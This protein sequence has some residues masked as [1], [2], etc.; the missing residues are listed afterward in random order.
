MTIVWSPRAV[1][2]LAAL[3]A[4]IARQNPSAAANIGAALLKSVDGLARFPQAGRAGRIAGTREWVVPGTPS[5]MAY[6]AAA[7]RLEILAVFHGRQAWP[8]HL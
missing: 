4:H 5:V 6:R 3:R 2:H 8:E 7:E 1:A